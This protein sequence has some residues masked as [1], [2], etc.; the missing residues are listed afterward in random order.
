MTDTAT[1]TAPDAAPAAESPTGEAPEGTTPEETTPDAEILAA[2]KDLGVEPDADGKID[3][4]D[5]VAL[6][7]TVK[8]LRDQVRAHEAAERRREEEL[9]EQR[10][11]ELPEQERMI[12]EARAAGRAEA[13]SEARIE[14]VGVQITSAA[15]EAG[16]ADPADAASFLGDLSKIK[17]PKAAVAKLAEAKPY[18]LKPAAPAG[19][20]VEQGPR[21]TAKPGGEVD[22]I[23]AAVR[24]RNRHA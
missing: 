17:D 21:G 8:T 20:K 14:M 4:K 9:E 16:F 22:F 5:H 13:L 1:A 2:L 23:K 19:V 15:T 10:R 6:V 12:E 24:G 3:P 18:L 7:T 11:K